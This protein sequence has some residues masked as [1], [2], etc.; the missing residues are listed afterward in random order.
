MTVLIITEQNGGTLRK[1]A[2]EA[3]SEGR[4][5]ADAAGTDLCALIMGSR[6]GDL[7][8]GAAALGADR[9]LTAD[10]DILND[11]SD[12]WTAAAAA[13]VDRCGA[14]T[15][16]IGA[17]SIGRDLAA[18]L[19]AR[20]DAAVAMDCVALTADGGRLAA[21]R[22]MYGGKVMADVELTG[23]PRIIAL[24]P[25]AVVV[26]EKAGRGETEA[27]DLGEIAPALSL[28]GKEIQT[29]G[30]DITEADIVVTGGRGVGGPDFSALEALAGKLGGAVGASR[31]A[32]DEGWRPHSDQ[33]G[34]TGKTVA[35]TLYFACGVSGAIQHLAGM[36]SSR[37]IVAVNKD[38]DAPIFEKADYG[39]T[40]DLAEIIPAITAALDG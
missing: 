40:G 10:A 6:A 3:L 22:P 21:T 26:A 25:N 11:Y 7:A 29:G 19:A 32:V 39:I 36:S 34:Q 1:T 27:L 9:I 12:A 37:V 17:S 33:V 24:R 13:A 15:I 38:P 5:L 16:L 14:D 20:L 2:S 30:V 35:P 18:R 28:V 4:R 8:A 31:S 23:T